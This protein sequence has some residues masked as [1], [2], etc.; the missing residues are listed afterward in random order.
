MGND[1]SKERAGLQCRG[2]GIW[3][4]SRKHPGTQGTGL[5]GREGGAGVSIP[6]TACPLSAGSTGSSGASCTG[7]AGA[8]L[9]AAAHVTVSWHRA[10]ST[11]LRC[12]RRGC[13]NPPLPR[14]CGGVSL[15]ADHWAGVRTAE[16]GNAILK[17]GA[18]QVDTRSWQLQEGRPGYLEAGAGSTGPWGQQPSLPPAPRTVAVG[19]PKLWRS[20]IK[21]RYV[22]QL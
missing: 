18:L 10:L 2:G 15:G 12:P 9:P 6:P 8:A 19:S 4:D 22:Q 20:P 3:G 14:V 5:G 17:A 16:P 1:A 13:A 7:L 11:S 21:S